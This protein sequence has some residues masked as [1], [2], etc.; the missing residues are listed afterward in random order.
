MKGARENEVI[1]QFS[2]NKSSIFMQI[3]V[4]VGSTFFGIS[5][6]E[7]EGIEF[8][9]AAKHPQKF[10]RLKKPPKRLQINDVQ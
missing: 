6:F 10:W 1:S 7:K 8:I 5:G 4:F 9:G 3:Q 2:N